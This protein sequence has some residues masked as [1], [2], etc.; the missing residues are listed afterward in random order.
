MI[1]IRRDWIAAA[2][3]L[4][5]IGWWYSPI[6]PR[7]LPF[8]AQAPGFAQACLPPPSVAAGAEPLQTAVPAELHPYRLEAGTLTPL[9]G[10]SIEGRLLSRRDYRADRL[11]EFAPTD[12]AMAWG[13]MRED[14]VLSRMTFRQEVRFLSYYWADRPPLPLQ[15]IGRS[16]ANLHIIPADAAVARALKRTRA[17]EQVRVDGWLVRIDAKDGW[18][19]VSSLSRDDQ[20]AGACE[21]VYACAIRAR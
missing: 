4:S 14:A 12:L 1:A 5:A 13:R 9:A 21:I 8:P 6:S 16:S 2:L 11:A 18:Q 17:G 3:V 15:E 19:A 10:F 20:G 7:P